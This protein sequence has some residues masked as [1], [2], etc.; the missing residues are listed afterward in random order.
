VW[1]GRI[2]S[3]LQGPECHCPCWAAVDRTTWLAMDDSRW[4]LGVLLREELS[5]QRFQRI[6]S[7]R[8]SRKE[9]KDKD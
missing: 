3:P 4:V 9:L 1:R 8:R 6:F 2:F 7:G 5:P